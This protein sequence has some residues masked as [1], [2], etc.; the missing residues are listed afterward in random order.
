MKFKSNPNSSSLHAYFGTIPSAVRTRGGAA[1]NPHLDVWSIREGTFFLQLQFD[2]LPELGDEFRAAFRAVLVW[3]AENAS[4]PH[5]RNMFY[6]SR[7]LFQFKFDTNMAAVGEITSVDLLN[8]KD[9]VGKPREWYLGSLSGFLAQ[10]HALGFAGITSD[11][12]VLLRQMR[13]KGNLKGVS[14][15]TMDPVSGP[16]TAIE[17]EALQHELNQAYGEHRVALGEYVLCWLFMMLG[18]RP[19]QYAALKVCDVAALPGKSGLVTY[20]LSMPRGKGRE[21]NP[22]REFKNRI[23]TPQIGKLV[24]SYAWQVQERFT[25]LL[26]DPRDAP[27]FPGKAVQGGPEGYVYHLTAAAL[28]ERLNATLARLKT[29]SE[30]TGALMHINPKRFRQTIGTRAAEEGHGELVIA[31][32]LDHS[33]TQNVGVY[34]SST[35]AIVERI[36]RAVAMLMAP[37]AQAFAGKLIKGASEASLSGSPSNQIRAPNITNSF[38]AISSCGK[39]GFCGFLKPIACYTCN[40]FEPWLDGPHERVLEYFLSERERLTRTADMRI[41]SVND[42]AILAVAR[43]IQLCAET[44]ETGGASNV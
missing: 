37:L 26:A 35:P 28:G 19:S 42:R 5:L 8:Y 22:R 24:L 18:Q 41:A 30:R 17:L 38:A 11:A 31:E 2:L 40:S 16:Y 43:V 33:D 7:D 6:R 36:D 3:Y 32:L 39:H 1:F 13:L 34:V 14:T 23:L 10:W 44:R 21:S 12:I 15:A 27:L 25:G 9:H 20:S 4:L 29:V